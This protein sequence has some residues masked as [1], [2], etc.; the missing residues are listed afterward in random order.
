[1]P[2]IINSVGVNI[3]IIDQRLHEL[4]DYHDSTTLIGMIIIPDNDI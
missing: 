3:A 4:F 1:M 2:N